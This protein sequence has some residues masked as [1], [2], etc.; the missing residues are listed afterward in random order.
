AVFHLEFGGLESLRQFYAERAFDETLAREADVGP[1]LGKDYIAEA[2][3]TGVYATRGRVGEH[4]D[5]RHAGFV[6][7]ADSIGGFG[8]LHEGE[9]AF[10]HARAARRGEAHETQP[11]PDGVGR[12]ADESFAEGRSHGRHDETRVHGAE[13]AGFAFY[14]AKAGHQRLVEAGGLL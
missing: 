9:D 11:V 8:H 14:R 2:R 3:E 5:E 12:C 13:D 4:R 7:F 1:G 6:H 10:L